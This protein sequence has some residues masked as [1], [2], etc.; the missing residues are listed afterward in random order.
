VDCS[1][2]PTSMKESR[3][4][5]CNS[6]GWEDSLVS[7]LPSEEESEGDPSCSQLFMVREMT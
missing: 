2:D 6:G 5:S 4:L 3:R 7:S 1:L